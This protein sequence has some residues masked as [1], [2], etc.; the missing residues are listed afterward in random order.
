MTETIRLTVCVDAET[1]SR[2]EALCRTTYRSK[3]G[4]LRCL[5]RAEWERQTPRSARPAPVVSPVRR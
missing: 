2:L 4:M 5:I 1:M 3:S